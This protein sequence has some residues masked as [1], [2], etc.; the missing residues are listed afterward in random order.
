VPHELVTRA[1]R[2]GAGLLFFT[3]AA[4]AE[5]A[6]AADGGRVARAALRIWGGSLGFGFRVRVQGFGFRV[7][8]QGLGFR[9]QGF[10]FRVSG[11]EFW[12]SG[13]GLGFGVSIGG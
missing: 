1:A 11:L 6:P 8:G 9:V 12:V 4:G 7:Q 10:G 3:L 5:A 13:S 2:P